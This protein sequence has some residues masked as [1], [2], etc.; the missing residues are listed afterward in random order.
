MCI[1][2]FV[3]Y[4]VYWVLFIGVN[5]FDMGVE[6]CFDNDC[7]CVMRVFVGIGFVWG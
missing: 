3:G 4:G 5:K 7:V 1:F 2:I 6:E